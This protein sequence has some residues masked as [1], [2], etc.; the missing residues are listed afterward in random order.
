M[1]SRIQVYWDPEDL[2]MK[3]LEE[4]IDSMRSYNPTK[5]TT[6][7]GIK[8]QLPMDTLRVLIGAVRAVD[9]ECKITLTGTF[10]D[11]GNQLQLFGPDQIELAGVEQGTLSDLVGT[12]G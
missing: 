9:G 8:G 3:N 11:N 2:S 6:T 5:I 10:S 12:K 1:S 4:S 7:V